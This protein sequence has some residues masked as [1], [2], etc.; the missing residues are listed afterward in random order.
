MTPRLNPND[1]SFKSYLYVLAVITS[2]LPSLKDNYQTWPTL[3]T[4]VNKAVQDLRDEN[5]LK[6]YEK[7]RI[8][9]LDRNLI[10]KNLN[11]WTDM[12]GKLICDIYIHY[13]LQEDIVL[14][15]ETDKKELEDNDLIILSTTPKEKKV[16]L[17][18]IKQI[19]NTVSRY[20]N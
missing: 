2:H 16:I 3:Y 8:V 10:L 6:D 5:R 13:N 19:L 14:T 20:S 18:I 12:K 9:D 4:N 1:T 17:I 11:F 15:T 7:D